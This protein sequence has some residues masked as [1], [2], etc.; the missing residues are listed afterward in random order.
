FG[1]DHGG[2]KVTAVEF[3]DF[4]EY[5]TDKK[6]DKFFGP[7]LK[8]KGLPAKSAKEE[9]SSTQGSSLYTL[10]SFHNELERTLIVYGTADEINSNREAAEALQKAIRQL[11]SNITVKIKTDKEMAEEDC[12]NH[13][14]LLIGRPDSNSLIEKFQKALPIQFGYRSFVVNKDCYANASSAV[15]TAGNNPL[16][17]RY[18]LVI[19]AGLSGA[20]T[21]QASVGFFNYGDS[22]GAEVIVAPKYGKTKALVMP[23]RDSTYQAKGSR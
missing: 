6:L 2:K 9:Q 15:L 8:E 13:H 23:T 3:Q 12:K 16:N 11:H 19:I 14:L 20:S 18:S 5:K 1:K 21:L 17:D 7:W 22:E 4:I 10:L